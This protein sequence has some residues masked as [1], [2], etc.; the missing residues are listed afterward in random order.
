MTATI[1]K[2]LP[3]DEVRIL[4]TYINCGVYHDYHFEEVFDAL[5]VPAN[6]TLDRISIAVAQILLNPIQGTLPNWGSVRDD[7]EVILGRLRK[8]R[9]KDARLNFNP[10]HVCT[11]NWA[12]SAP[13]LCWPEAYHVTYLPGFNKYIIT[14]SRDGND[15]FGCTDN[16]IGFENSDLSPE[17]AA[18]LAIVAYW[19]VQV[20]DWSQDRWVYLFNE[21]LINSETANYW[22]D[23]TWPD[24]VPEEDWDCED[25]DN[26]ATTASGQE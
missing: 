26:L 4:E 8:N 20:R 9:S 13:G 24:T 18:R 17:E 19:K 1:L 11:I 14:A 10:H 21:G 15:T 16:A 7:G 12:D 2:L 23:E 25:E 6:S 22:A 5:G 3:D